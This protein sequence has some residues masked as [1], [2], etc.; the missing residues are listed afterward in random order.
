MEHFVNKT[1]T[2]ASEKD[3]WQTPIAL[4][5]ALDQE[6]D[7]DVDICASED[8]HLLPDYFTE[9]RSALTNHWNVYTRL[10][11]AFINPPYSQ[12]QV[13]MERAAEQA[14]LHNITVV[15]L[16]NANTDT[17]WFSD[18]VKSANEVRLLTGRVAFVKPDGKKASGNPK[19][20]C[21]IIWRGNCK[22][23]CQITMVD[24]KVLEQI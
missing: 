12:T 24:R 7:F 5:N 13:F 2:P 4:F 9:E 20:Q 8:N 17:Q 10:F 18:A 11:S 6:F 21:L 15:A 23:P 3:L 16:V 1:D 19:G 22:T 14:K